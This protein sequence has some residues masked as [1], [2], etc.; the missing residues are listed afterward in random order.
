M[1][2]TITYF[3]M[4][5]RAEL[6]K[7]CAAAG[8]VEL[9]YN[10]IDM[11]PHKEF[12]PSLTPP[13]PSTVPVL[14]D[15]DLT[16]YQSLAI[17]TYICNLSPKFAALTPKQKAKD[18]MFAAIKEDLMQGGAPYLFGKPNGPEELPPIL[19][20]I[21]TLVEDQCPES[22]YVNG[23]DFPTKADLTVVNLVKGFMPYAACQ[24]VAKYDM[25]AHPKMMRICADAVEAPGVKEYLAS[26]ECNMEANP[27]NL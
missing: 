8:G 1:V 25:T 9:K 21:F 20:K 22:G 17:E 26:P 11:G 18:D 12:G 4:A 16:F 5:G 23:L 19:N 7:L 2:P 10:K 14:Q 6:A 15:G 13:L 24:K 27:F 3:P